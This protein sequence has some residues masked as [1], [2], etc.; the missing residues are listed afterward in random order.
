MLRSEFQERPRARVRIGT[1]A[2]DHDRSQTGSRA[3]PHS[4]ITSWTLIPLPEGE[5][6]LCETGRLQ[7]SRFRQNLPTRKPN[8]LS[9]GPGHRGTTRLQLFSGF[10][11]WGF[12][13]QTGRRS[14]SERRICSGVK[15]HKFRRADI[16]SKQR[17]GVYL[18]GPLRHGRRPKGVAV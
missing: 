17:S 13:Q 5:R 1:M 9:G 6:C 10:P 15:A 12:N 4:P 3:G 11:K 16:G 7:Y 8:V 18:V 14:I 2:M